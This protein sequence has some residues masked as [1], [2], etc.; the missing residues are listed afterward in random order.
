M[1]IYTVLSR[2]YDLLDST[3]FAKKDHNPRAVINEM[4]QG[5][6]A[7]VLDMCCGTLANTM[8]IAR[9]HEK[10]R[11]LGIDLSEPMLQVARKKVQKNKTN[12]VILEQMDATR[13]PLK[14]NTYDYIVIGLALHEMN[15]KLQRDLLK[16]AHRLLK[17]DGRL[18]V[19][20]WEK[21][22]RRIQ[23]LLY[24]PLL[25][26]EEGGCES[27]KHFYHCDKE[28]FF[29]DNGFDVCTAV[30]CNYSVVLELRKEKN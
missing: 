2:M 12:N 26:L 13:T 7:E 17:D 30:H 19:L 29:Q 27:F 1:N 24:F 5:E 23:R 9:K 11:I 18:I 4:I 14:S 10:A 6:N 21:P 20:E 28:L 16:E 25:V 22:Q 15:P 8:P 3:Y